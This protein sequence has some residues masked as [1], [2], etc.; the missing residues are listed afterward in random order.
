M[1]QQSFYRVDQLFS[2]L[3][4]HQLPQLSALLAKLHLAPMEQQSMVV[5]RL[6]RQQQPHLWL[7][8]LGSQQQQVQYR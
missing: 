1:H 3:I 7:V 2:D 4:L 8:A 5:K 6:R